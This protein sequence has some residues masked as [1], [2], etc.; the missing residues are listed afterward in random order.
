VEVVI[1]G[2]RH[3]DTQLFHDDFACAV[4]EAPILVIELVK[5]LPRKRQISACDLVY[6]GKIMMKEPCAQK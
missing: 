2:K 3:F 5:C 1:E 6:F 4:S